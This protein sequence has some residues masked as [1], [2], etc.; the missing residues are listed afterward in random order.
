M[1]AW[2]W[3]YSWSRLLYDQHQLRP[4]ELEQLLQLIEIFGMNVKDDTGETGFIAMDFDGG[5][6][7]GE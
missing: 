4:T 6:R 3:R 1:E 5:L 2:L 7:G